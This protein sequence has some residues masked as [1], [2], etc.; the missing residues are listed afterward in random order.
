MLSGVAA[1]QVRRLADRD[2][3]EL[4]YA[5]V[6]D[7]L[8]DCL[9][10]IERPPSALEI[11]GWRRGVHTRDAAALVQDRLPGAGKDYRI[12]YTGMTR[13]HRRLDPYLP[14]ATWLATRIVTPNEWALLALRVRPLGPRAH[15]KVWP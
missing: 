11:N 14:E 4:I 1:E 13:G 2:V 6:N 5:I 15:T 8:G 3:Q 9:P 10:P 12:V 7:E